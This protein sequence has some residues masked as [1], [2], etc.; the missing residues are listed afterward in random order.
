[1]KKLSDL[2]NHHSRCVCY[3]VDNPR[4]SQ[5]EFH[6]C[7]EY[8]DSTDGRLSRSNW[9]IENA[10]RSMRDYSNCQFIINSNQL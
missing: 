10:A 5:F 8:D 6:L 3:D 1:M 7:W 2:W 4:L 9:S